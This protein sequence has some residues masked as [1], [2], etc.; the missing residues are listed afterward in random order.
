V[1]LGGGL[2]G[3]SGN[4]AAGRYVREGISEGDEISVDGIEGT[5]EEIGHAAVVLRS[6]DGYLYRVPNRTL[7]EGVV[8]KRA[9]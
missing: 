2:I 8:R 5:V 4:I 1:A 3:L 7:L 9:G 6:E